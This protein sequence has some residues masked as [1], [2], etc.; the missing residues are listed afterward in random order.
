MIKTVEITDE[1]AEI[2]ARFAYRVIAEL[3]DTLDFLLANPRT[4]RS[5]LEFHA[6]SRGFPVGEYLI[7]YRVL[8]EIPEIV[9]IAHGRRDL[10]ALVVSSLR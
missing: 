9:Y 10:A 8:E 3:G 4:S 7:L 6:D 5:R 2:V 1:T